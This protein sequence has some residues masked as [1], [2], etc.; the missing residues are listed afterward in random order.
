MCQASPAVRY[1][2]K[3]RI[4]KR[5]RFRLPKSMRHPYQGLSFLG[6]SILL[7]PRF[8]FSAKTLLYF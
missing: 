8:C 3:M 6:G 2:Q 1:L 7:H 4:D 5:N